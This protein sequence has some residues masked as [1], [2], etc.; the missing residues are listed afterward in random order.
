MNSDVTIVTAFLDIGRGSWENFRRGNDFYL[1][2]FRNM[3]SAK[4]DIVVFTESRFFDDIHS[5]RSGIKTI[6]IDGIYEE[7]ASLLSSIEAIQK[8]DEFKKWVADPKLP[9]YRSPEYV[10]IN[11]MKSYF[12]KTAVEMGLIHTE[13]SAWLDFGY[14]REPKR[15]PPDTHLTFDTKGKINLFTMSG[16]DLNFSYE[17]IKEIVRTNT[18]K[19]QGCHMVAP[20]HMWAWLFKEMTYNLNKLMSDGM[21]DDDQTL[22]LM[23]YIN[24][25]DNFR[26]VRG[27]RTWFDIFIDNSLR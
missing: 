14:V 20:N 4:N 27:S 26:L 22:L 19:I 5:M 1:D 18:V 15:C 17:K 25:P 12:L 2:N 7:Y 13:V 23:S 21:V 16:N 3:T 10:F 24:H 11:Y 8:S 9:E 6:S